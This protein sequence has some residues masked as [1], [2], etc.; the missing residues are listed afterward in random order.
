MVPMKG[1]RSQVILS[2]KTPFPSRV[3]P[4]GPGKCLMMCVK[5]PLH[6]D[7]F[8]ESLRGPTPGT[9]HVTPCS[10]TTIFSMV[11]ASRSP[12]LAPST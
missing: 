6:S 12:F 3:V 1:F 2:L 9:K 5:G 7:H 4:L 10:S 8:F 11:T